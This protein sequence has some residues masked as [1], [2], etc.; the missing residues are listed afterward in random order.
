MPIRPRP[1]AETS[2]PVVPSVRVSM[3]STDNRRL[4][5]ALMPSQVGDPA[6]HAFAEALDEPHR[7][8]GPRHDV[9]LF[10]TD[11]CVWGELVSEPS[12]GL[13]VGSARCGPQNGLADPVVVGA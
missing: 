13:G 10:D 12:R 9:Y 11:A 2:G 1:R 7:V 5:R 3:A 8:A 4:R 6:H